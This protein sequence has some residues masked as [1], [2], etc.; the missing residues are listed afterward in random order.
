M[1]LD[2]DFKAAAEWLACRFRRGARVKGEVD[3]TVAQ[4]RVEDYVLSVSDDE[5]AVWTD[6][7]AS[8]LPHGILQV[9]LKWSEEYKLLH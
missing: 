6:P 4:R 1:I 8:P 9:A 7:L 3:R 5:I 2:F